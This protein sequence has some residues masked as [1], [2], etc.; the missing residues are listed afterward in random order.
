MKRFFTNSVLF[1]PVIIALLFIFCF[2]PLSAN[3]ALKNIRFTENKGQWHP[4]VLHRLNLYNGAM[5]LEKD[6]ITYHFLHEDDLKIF[7]H[8][9]HHSEDDF[10]NE[11]PN[12]TLNDFR[13]HSFQVKFK[14]CNPEPVVRGNHAFQGYSNF[15]L[16]ND[17]TKWTSFVKTYNEV[18]YNN[19]YNGIDLHF[20]EAE[21]HLKYQFHVSAQADATLIQLEFEGIEKI[22]L[23]DG[24]LF[25]TTSVN[26]IQEMK[27]YS[28]QV[29]NGKTIEVPSAFLLK[30]NIVSF[31]FHKGYN[32]KYPLVIDPVLVFSTYTG[33]TA[34]N[35]GFTATYDDDGNFYAG[36]IA[37]D[38][39]YPTTAGAYRQTYSG[40]VDV[41][42]TKYNPLGTGLIYSTYIGGVSD[43]APS[44]LVVNADNELI[45]LGVTGSSNFPVSA[46]AYD[47]SFNGG[48]AVSFQQNGTTFTAGTD[49]FVAKLSAD[50]SRLLGSTFI[51]GTNNDGINHNTTTS[52]Q[53]NYGDQF[54]GEVIVDED[55]FI[56]LVSSTKSPDFPVVGGF[57]SALSG[58][59]DACVIKLNPAL[60]S[61]VW[62]SYL[63]GNNVDAGY[64]LKLNPVNFDL[65]VCGGTASA[66]FPGTQGGLNATYRGGNADGYIARISNNGSILVA[67]TYLGTNQYDQTYFVETDAD[68]NI[69]TV[70][71]TRGQYPVINATYFN[72][73][74]AQFIHKLNPQLNATIYATTFGS[75]S[76]LINISPT[77]FLVDYCEN[78]YV[79]GWGGNVNNGWNANTGN[80]FGMPATV[81]AFQ[82]STDGSDFYFIVFAK[83]AASLVY[84]TYFGG[85]GSYE[86]V[87]GGTSRFDKHGIMY[88]AVC[89]G[90]S[91]CVGCPG[92]SLF[93]STPGVWSNTNN[94]FNCNLGS[95]K[96][97]FQIDL[98][99][100]DITAFPEAI[101][102]PP[103]TVQFSDNGF[104]ATSWL[105]IFGDGD[106][107]TLQNPVHTFTEPGVYTVKLVGSDTPCNISISDSAFLT[108]TVIDDSFYVDFTFTQGDGCDSVLVNFNT[109]SVNIDS[110]RWDFGDGNFSSALNP[111]HI[112]YSEGTFD[113]TL[114]AYSGSQCDSNATITQSINI[115]FGREINI[116][117][118]GDTACAEKEIIFSGVTGSPGATYFWNFGD[119]TYSTERNPQHFYNI[120]GNYTVTLIVTDSSF[121]CDITDTATANIYIAP[122]NVIADFSTDKNEYEL[123][124]TVKFT[125][126]S[127]NAT[128]YRWDFGDGDY[129]TKTNPTHIYIREGEF[130]V[131]LNAYNDL[132]CEDSICKPLKII[133]KGLVDVANAFSPNG[134][135]QNDIIYVKGYGIE[136]LEFRI[137]NRWG[138]LVFESNNI[139]VGWDGT[140]KGIA[141]E[142]EVY[143]YTLKAKFKDGNESGLRKGNITLL[144]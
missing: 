24:N 51:G 12:E 90:C 110:V 61:V 67:A 63:G 142:M 76:S 128:S 81:D 118:S 60:S 75:G 101:G 1:R 109:S 77:A 144:R 55:G 106:S 134:D 103:L 54:R 8:K 78:V 135:G 140:Y 130:T 84:A 45:I 124:E 88:Q 108:I 39:G 43:E 137:Y 73:N 65:Y 62:S 119:N 113:V 100:V 114:T 16:G 117:L 79:S 72:A 132:G 97:E 95:I 9:H 85:N 64:S 28:Y 56:Y 3:D 122:N 96:F 27:P 25:Y 133:F 6:R 34:D 143:V 31:V 13:Y 58:T 57:L 89:A 126:K 83:D 68:G 91:A 5:F 99:K 131:C 40:G 46:N 123:Y 36:G 41:S 69:Y 29:I 42:I 47:N 23:K 49:I 125:N 11:D 82:S 20:A 18:Y 59:Q 98:V 38:I 74:G 111:Q 93:P 66:N 7:H 48:V 17:H 102:C 53:H 94:S 138:E 50:G 112:Y 15:Y 139:N 141:Q 19:L 104:N 129:S 92:T 44:S 33:S 87:D 116:E 71:Q 80:T 52:L 21:N 32:K 107:S 30:E 4:N 86:H 14:N 2:Y 22:Y 121:Y 136:E 37:F 120:P 127:Q 10:I 105:W 70:G 26:E 115:V 35:F